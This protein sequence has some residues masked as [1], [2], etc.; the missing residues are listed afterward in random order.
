MAPSSRP[1]DINSV[2]KIEGFLSPIEAVLQFLLKSN[3]TTS[4]TPPIKWADH[5]VI[6]Y[7]VTKESI[8]EP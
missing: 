3:L 8:I 2:D 7:W 1:P 6:D 5:G 4:L